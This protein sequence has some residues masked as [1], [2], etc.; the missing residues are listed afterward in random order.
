MKT[1]NLKYREVSILLGLSIFLLL[2]IK[3]IIPNF[4][5]VILV[6][7]LSFY[8]FPIKLIRNRIGDIQKQSL[9]SDIILSISL[10]L[11][12]IGI[13]MSDPFILSIFAIVNFF[14]IIYLVFL[15]KNLA[16][17]RGIILNHIILIFLLQMVR[18]M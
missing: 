10:I 3:D 9:A 5:S 16:N 18:Y 7:V 14:F 13:Y 12:I 4:I 11:L 1:L 8:F 2:S 17:Y 15:G 6:L